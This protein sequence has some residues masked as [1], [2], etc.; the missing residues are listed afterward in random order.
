M[1]TEL[2]VPVA[3]FAELLADLISDSSETAQ[4]VLR[5]ARAVATEEA[6]AWKVWTGYDYPK[7][8]ID[9]LA[10][11]GTVIYNCW[12]NAGDAVRLTPPDTGQPVEDVQFYRKAVRPTVPEKPLPSF[13]DVIGIYNQEAP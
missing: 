11:D 8:E 10:R 7:T 9:V 1:A 4:F 5:T 3:R 13:E 6:D 2:P 12:P